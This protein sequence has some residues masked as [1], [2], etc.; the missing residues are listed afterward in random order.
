MPMF[1]NTLPIIFAF[2]HLLN[3]IEAGI[4]LSSIFLLVYYNAPAVEKNWIQPKFKNTYFFLRAM[5]MGEASLMYAFWPFFVFAN[6][7]LFYVDYRVMNVTYTIA[8]WKTIHIM[9]FLPIIWWTTSVW[10]CSK[11]TGKRLFNGAA[12]TITIYMF[13]EYGLRFI[14]ST[15]FPNTFF[16][17]RLLI[18]EIGDCL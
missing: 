4:F 11:H 14:I 8:S 3:P 10:R 9:L 1:I 6:V 5:W 12:R 2:T 13:L 15:K 17:C 16:D 7:A 18:M